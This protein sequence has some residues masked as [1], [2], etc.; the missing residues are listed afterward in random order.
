[1]VAVILLK[2]EEKDAGKVYHTT[3]TGREGGKEG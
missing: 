3:M 2:G 1:V